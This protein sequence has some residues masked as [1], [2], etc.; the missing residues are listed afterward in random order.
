MEKD[1]ENWVAT[2]PELLFGVERVLVIGQSV[3][4]QQM[5]DI[6]ALDA[7]GRLVVVEMKRDWSDRSTVGQLL[8]YAA[9]MAEST[10]D[11][12]EGLA[13]A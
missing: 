4:G 9:R 11:D 8:E 5:A 13:R 3:S 10:Y 6:L 12:L 7:D 1:L 2:H